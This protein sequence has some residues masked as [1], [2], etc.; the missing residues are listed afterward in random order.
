MNDDP[1]TNPKLN[2]LTGFRT[3][4][5]GEPETRTR[6]LVMNFDG[7]GISIT[8]SQGDTLPRVVQQLELVAAHLR[9]IYLGEKK[10]SDQPATLAPHET[11]LEELKRR[12]AYCAEELRPAV[13]LAA[14]Q[15]IAGEL[16]KVAH[17][18]GLCAHDV[19]F[20]IAGAK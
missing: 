8:V 20:L 14:Q 4:D 9:A 5:V 16:E 11:T 15:G 12:L 10:F 13:A 1:I 7:G 6:S 19:E 2:R 3:E 18:L 17:Q